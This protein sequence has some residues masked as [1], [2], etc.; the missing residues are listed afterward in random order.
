MNSLIKY[1]FHIFGIV[2][3][4]ILF[5][6]LI[7]K[8]STYDQTELI[9]KIEQQDAE[10]K[11][12]EDDIGTCGMIGREIVTKIQD[13]CKQNPIVMETSKILDVIDPFLST[14]VE[15]MNR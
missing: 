2:S 8:Y 6:I 5:I 15:G 7:F 14:S 9:E 11:S 12:L 10:I 4:M 13:V 1:K 3:L